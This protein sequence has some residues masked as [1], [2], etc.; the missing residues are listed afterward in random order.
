[1]KLT[2]RSTLR[3]AIVVV[4]RALDKAAIRAVLVGGA[5]ATVYS[6]GVHQSEDIDL[7]LQSA[8]SQEDLD[9]ALASVGFV[10]RHAQYFHRDTDF[11]VEFPRPP[12]SIGE[13]WRIVPVQLTVGRSML[14]ALSA[15]DSCR[16][17]LAQFYH[18]GDRQS[19]EVAIAIALR[20]R[21]N[22]TLIRKW[23]TGEGAVPKFSEFRAELAR[24]RALRRGG[25]TRLQ[26]DRRRR[27]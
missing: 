9:N 24:A 11:F 13:D 23:S 25:K 8:P 2:R 4:A 12:L 1:M 6:G 18:W 21:V 26:K 10:R 27:A 22:M 20:H 14:P 3:D 5:C 17:R 16:D 19:L 15:T 7:I